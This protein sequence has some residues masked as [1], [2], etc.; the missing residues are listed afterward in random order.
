M[1]TIHHEATAPQ[2][3]P[4]EMSPR[5]RARRSRALTRQT[6]AAYMFLSPW[7]AGFCLLTIVTTLFMRFFRRAFGARTTAATYVLVALIV[8]V[9]CTRPIYRTPFRAGGLYATLG[10]VFE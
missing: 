4:A 8:V 3:M 9:A 6:G 5:Q 1:A 2:R 10:Q 7:L